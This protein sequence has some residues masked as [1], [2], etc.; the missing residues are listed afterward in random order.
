LGDFDRIQLEIATPVV[1]QNN[2][3]QQFNFDLTN[4]SYISR[5]LSFKQAGIVRPQ[6]FPFKEAGLATTRQ[7]PYFCTRTAHCQ[8]LYTVRRFNE[9]QIDG[10][11]ETSSN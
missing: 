7:L 3:G 6:L 10:E 4:V 9:P 5:H 1:V 2:N 11:Q 8:L